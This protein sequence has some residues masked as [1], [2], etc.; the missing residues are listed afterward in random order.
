M[1]R[2]KKNEIAI[3]EYIILPVQD[4]AT[5]QLQQM[6]RRL[7]VSYISTVENSDFSSEGRIHSSHVN[8]LTFVSVA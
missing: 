1:P 4:P 3:H 7:Q 8:L 6:I 2:K 5:C